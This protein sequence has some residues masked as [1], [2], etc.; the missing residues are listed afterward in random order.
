[1]EEYKGIYYNDNAEQHFYE[2]GAHFKYKELYIIL[3]EIA[4]KANSKK[5][6]KTLKQVSFPTLLFFIY[7]I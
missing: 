7:R 2:G 4:K 5:I 3:E 6:P 1:M